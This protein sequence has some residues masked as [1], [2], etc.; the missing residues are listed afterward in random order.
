MSEEFRQPR[1]IATGAALPSSWLESISLAQC[2]QQAATGAAGVLHLVEAGHLQT[3]S[4]AEL[5]AAATA[6]CYQLRTQGC[7]PQTPVILHFA[8][9]HQLL[10]GLWACFWGGFVP[11]PIAVAPDYETLNSKTTLLREVVHSLDQPILLTDQSRQATVQQFCAANHLNA[12]VLAIESLLESRFDPASDLLDSYCYRPTDPA[13]LLFTSGSTGIPK[14][15][16]LS[17]RN[18]LAGVYGMATVNGLNAQS[19][20]LNWM[21]L[22]HVASLV[23]FHLTQVYTGCQQIQVAHARVLLEPLLWL[24]LVDRYRVTHTWAPNFAYGLI[25]DR[26][27]TVGQRDW[28][29]SCLQWMGNGA[30]AVVSKT[31]RR[32][33]EL[34]L[35]KGLGPTVVSPGYGMSETSAGIVHS[36]EFSRASTTDMDALVDVGQPIPGTSLR[37]VDAENQVLPEGAIGRLQVQGLNI[38]QGYYRRPDLNQAVFTADGW[39]ET[40]DLGFLQAGRLTITG[41]QKDVI[42]IN[43][44]NYYNHEIEAAVEELAEVAVSFTA[45]CAVRSSE[46]ASERLV[47]FYVPTGQVGEAGESS[48]TAPAVDDATI[49][50]IKAI[51][52]QVAQAIGI[53]PAV[54][55]PVFPAAIPKTNLGKIQRSQLVQ[56]F[57][58]GEF[59]ATVQ[60]VEQGLLQGRRQALPTSQIE[61]QIAAIWQT[62]L[63]IP[64][65]GVQDH[66]FELG[67]TSLTLMQVL[68]RLQEIQPTLT[69][70]TLF[71]YPTVAALAQYLTQQATASDSL[72]S[73]HRP[74]KRRGT[75]AANA[76]I[77]VIGMACRFPGANSPEQFWQNLSAGVESIAQLSDA[78]LLAAGVDRELL[79]HPNY[80]KASPILDC[81]I[82][83]FDA[84]FFGYSPKEASLLDPQ[85]R[86]LLE[87]TWE[88]LENAGYNPLAYDGA[89]GLY[90]GASMNTYLLNQVYPNR[91]QLDDQDSLQVLT[92]SSMG[93]FQLTTANDKDYLTTRISYKLNLKG[94]SVN[95]QTACSTSLVAVHLAR[96]SLLQGDCDLALAGGVS[97]HVPQTV[98]HLYQDGMILTTDGHCR[99]FDAQAS[100]T[101]FGSGA[102]MVVLKRLDQA[103]A[104]GDR[105]YAVIK[106]SAMGND[107]SNKVGYFAPSAAGQAAVT[108]SA[109]EVAG[110][111]SETIGYLEAH[112]TGTVLGDPI[113]IAG[114]T[115][116]FRMDTQKQ[117]FCA[118]GSVKTNVGHL[119]IASG[120]VGLI[121][122]VL[123]LHYQKIPPSLHFEQ[124]NPQID[125]ASSPFFVN[126][127]LQDWPRTDHPRRAGVNSLG[128]GGTNVHII[129][130]EAPQPTAQVPSP[131]SHHLLT[132]SAQTPEALRQ[133]AQQYLQWLPLEASVNLADLCFTANTGRVHFDY[134]LNLVAGSVTQL[135]QQ[136]QDWLRANA[137]PRR[138]SGS[139]AVA[140]LYPGQGSQYVGMGRDLYETAPVFRAAMDQCDQITRPMLGQS[141]L[142]V[143]WDEAVLLDQTLYTQPA[144][145]AVEYA[146]TCLWRSWGIQPAVVLGHSL[147]EYVAACVAGVFSLED[148]LKL[149]VTRARLMQ[150]LPTG[151]MTAVFTDEA[152]V[153]SEI[154]DAV[155]QIDIAAV[156][157]RTN[158]VISGETAAVARMIEQLTAKG[159][160]SRRLNVSHAFHSSMMQPIAAAF[161]RAARQVDYH[162]PEIPLIANLTGQLAD[163]SIA[164]PGYWCRHLHQPVNF[165]DSLDSLNQMGAVV[166][167]DC[168]AKPTLVRMIQ[169]E[170]GS[171]QSHL[172][173]SLHPHQPIW[174]SMVT[175]LGQLYQLGVAV[176]WQAVHADHH[177]QRLSL[178]TYPFQRQRYWLDRPFTPHSPKLEHSLLGQRIVLPQ[179]ILF[180]LQITATTPAF[181]QDHQVHQQ[182]IF[183]AAAF[184]EMGLAAG[185]KQLQTSTLRIQNLE[186]PQALWLSDQVCTLQLMLNPQTGEFQIDSFVEETQRQTHCAGQIAVAKPQVETVNL[187]EI[188]QML[189]EVRSRQQHY[190]FCQQQG[191]H[192]GVQFQL[193]QQIW[194]QAGTALAQIEWL[195][196]SEDYLLPPMLLD[197][198]FQ[199]IA[200]ALPETMPAT[201]LPVR[202]EQLTL[203]IPVVGLMWSYVQ[204]QPQAAGLSETLR[205]DVRLFNAAG[206]ICVQIT[207]L[208]L[209]RVEHPKAQPAMPWQNWFY[210]SEWQLQP[211]LK[212]HALRH[213]SFNQ[214]G[215]WLILADPYGIGLQLAGHLAGLNQICQVIY[216]EVAS[217]AWSNDS[218]AESI[219]SLEATDLSA[220]EHWI[221]QTSQQ[222]PLRGV[223]NLWSLAAVDQLD[224]PQ[225]AVEQSCRVSLHLLQA[226]ATVVFPQPPHCW[227]VTA[228]AQAVGLRSV[229][230][231]AQTCLWGMVKTARLEHP[232]LSMTCVDCD[233]ALLTSADQIAVHLLNELQ[234]RHQT[235]QVAF[236]GS[237]RYVA[238]LVQRSPEPAVPMQLTL[239]SRGTLAGLT[240]QPM[241][242]TA[243]ETHQVTIRVHATGLNFR[244]VLNALDQYPGE[245]GP[246]GL[247]CAGEVVAVGSAVTHLQ[248]GDWVMAIAAGSFATFVTVDARLVVKIPAGLSL[249]DAATLPTAFLTAG[250]ALQTVAKLRPGERVLIHA[251]AG[252]VGQAAIQIA[253]QIGAEIVAT[254]APTKWPLLQAQG[255][256]QIYSSRSLEFAAA[257]QQI[258]GVDVVLNSLSDE[259]IPHSLVTLR[260]SGRFVEIG[261]TGIWQPEQVRTL[262]P[263]VVYRTVDLMQITQQQPDQIHSLLTDLL[264]KFQTGELQP[265]PKQVF[266]ASQ[267]GAACR[268]MQQ[269]KH[270]GKL[271]V[272]QSMAATCRIRSKG[273]YLV[274][275]GL[276]GLGIKVAHWLAAQGAGHVILVGRQPHSDQAETAI[277][278][279]EQLGT[280]VTVLLADIADPAVPITLLPA[281]TKLYG[282]IHAAGVLDDGILLHQTWERFQTVLAAKVQ[283]AWNLHKLTQRQPLDFFVMFSSAASLIGSAGQANYAAA[284]AFLDGLAHFRQ[285]QGLPALSIN[286]S[287]WREVGIATQMPDLSQKVS[288]LITPDQGLEI[289]QYLLQQTAP[290][291]GVLPFSS[292]SSTANTVFTEPSQLVFS[293]DSWRQELQALSVDAAYAQLRSYVG[294][295]L[296]QV[297]GIAATAIDPQQGLSDLGLDSLTA[298]EFRN[299]LQ[300]HLDCRLPSTLLFDYP[301]LA[302]LTDHLVHRLELQLPSSTQLTAPMTELVEVEQL[303]ETEAEILLL[304]ELERLGE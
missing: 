241:T 298:V 119:N 212:H 160:A 149:V 176:D 173:V 106:G 32:F 4:Y 273:S 175:S 284:N 281:S 72:Q 199:T 43:G 94:P 144:L 274:T 156:N 192:Y 206:Q 49:A 167:L 135:Q 141:I 203:Q 204:L 179:Q 11:V 166:L 157:G 137:A 239:T 301:T 136:L 296:A 165:A 295:Q 193:I 291:I 83:A 293:T 269:G 280:T 256:Q 58:Q 214:P 147:G 180:Q 50:V 185:A 111:A 279:I 232:E 200:A 234:D 287:A 97:V 60:Q 107:G 37:I 86:L 231:P 170:R 129:L 248:R 164:D 62:V 128:I 187:S 259:F 172:L 29:L 48:Q 183:P 302:R 122:A 251:A 229:T 100:G 3:Q 276:G 133:L 182:V 292:E 70:V 38:M 216:P 260:P 19:V 27:A 283:G 233:P 138:A 87:C 235:D 285:G 282:V 77:A 99:A 253:R 121:K 9:S 92:L 5:L 220:L 12:T 115:Q 6:V 198:A 186:I 218:R 112:G 247:E 145:F 245:A 191:I 67:G 93:G 45:A 252:A 8:D 53:T 134:R 96:Q 150:T 34:L 177:C 82:A 36:H 270:T 246:L 158:I 66:F 143:L 289:L 208:I 21:P 103:M 74:H 223:I 297:L 266:P 40:G 190:Q 120:I 303:S 91:H 41:R 13:L 88:S 294:Q 123:S 153:Q 75:P 54:V 155:D 39:F 227:F 154:A 89:I 262:R 161:E 267:V 163:A 236:C 98:G 20:S 290:Q 35:P 263:D 71:Q 104:D 209:K 271:V 255:I 197:A 55:I 25:S 272:A 205:A 230:S 238:K 299:L 237:E 217:A 258:G 15:V 101:I 14:G 244:D 117:Q 151:A 68:Q 116:A 207:G 57:V 168:G 162:L 28:D 18:L 250:Y 140:F 61:Q 108:A 243:P 31:T 2:L 125:F 59:A 90:A 278:S 30:E 56:R 304:Q 1:S 196:T 264:S 219:A 22:E 225:Q 131:R 277:R 221:I 240:W 189:P 213:H 76:D 148:A 52:R 132:L 79:Q 65:V 23:M 64:T 174:Q 124:P 152:T 130:E 69:A 63:R 249:S 118:I 24:D 261:K 16:Q 159:I 202:I 215:S 265:L 181:L 44:V 17:E 46:D 113:E 95:V 211:S 178:P 51:R 110:I 42:I 171:E 169:A 228:G 242:P 184:V 142:P 47:I 10:T 85:Q 105:I 81:D 188:Q 201:Y 224:Q 139:P 126:T 257:I 7:Q 33:L 226:L 78:E 127:Q 109:I 286:W 114:L 194:Y 275:G 222:A 26:A 80:V 288:S 210:Q 146:L 300:K 254:A 102:G 84:Q 268:L 73:L 195:Q